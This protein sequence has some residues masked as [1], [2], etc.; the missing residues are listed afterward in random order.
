[1]LV[2]HVVALHPG[3]RRVRDDFGDI[4]SGQVNRAQN[5]G[6]N[7]AGGGGFRTVGK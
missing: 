3:R 2:A 1:L 5:R 6:E 4:V 7:I